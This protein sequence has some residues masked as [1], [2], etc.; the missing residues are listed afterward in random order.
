[1]GNS[2]P[3]RTH[4]P[5]GFSPKVKKGREEIEENQFLNAGW[6]VHVEKIREVLHHINNPN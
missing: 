6:G 2:K 3:D 4:L 1:L 5:L